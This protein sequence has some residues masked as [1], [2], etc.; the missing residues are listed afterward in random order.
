MT[1]AINICHRQVLKHYSKL[2][3]AVYQG[4]KC[5]F[6]LAEPFLSD[7]SMTIF[8]LFAHTWQQN[9]VMSENL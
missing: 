3:I 8:S 6:H 2:S 7:K 5:V 1:K 4:D 9:V